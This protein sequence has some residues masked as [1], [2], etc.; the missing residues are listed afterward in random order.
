M[1]LCQITGNLHTLICFFY[2]GNKVYN[3]EVPELFYQEHFCMQMFLFQIHIDIPRMSP[4]ALILE[5]KVTEASIIA[6]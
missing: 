4:E 6:R 2:I 3:C 5:P 1:K